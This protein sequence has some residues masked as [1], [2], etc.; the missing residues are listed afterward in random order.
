MRARGLSVLLALAALPAIALETTQ[1]P[2]PPEAEARM[3]ELQQAIIARDS[4]PA[5]R[6]QAR[7]ELANLLK[8]PAGQARGRTPDEKPV[9]AARAAIQPYPSVVAP[10]YVAPA[11]PP[12]GGVAQVEVVVPPKPIVIP[13]TGA[14]LTPSGKFAIDPRTGHV[15]HETPGGYVDPRTG[16]FSPR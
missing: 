9:R 2:P 11:P 14:A 10:A 3:R 7:E 15:L 16:R 1:W 8:S 6:E 4:T 13:Q 5:E 12:P